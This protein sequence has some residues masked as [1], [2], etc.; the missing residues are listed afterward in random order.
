M[1]YRAWFAQSFPVTWLQN[2]VA[3]RFLGMWGTLMDITSDGMLEGLYAPWLAHGD[4]KSS[5]VLQLIGSERRM[6]RFVGESAANYRLRLMAAWDLHEYA[7][8]A[9]VVERVLAAMGLSAEVV[10]MSEWNWDDRPEDWSR[11]WVVIHQPHP[12]TQRLWGEEPVGSGMTYGD[13]AFTYG[14]SMTIN[15]VETLRRTIRHWKPGHM[16]CQHIIVVFHEA[17]WLAD[18][19]DGTWMSADARNPAAIYIAG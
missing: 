12:W 2:E 1:S 14:S 3:S 5:D 6:P 11:F 4:A 15:E 10:E 9:Q 8:T 13:P 19:P 17:E 18:Q 7:G 16:R